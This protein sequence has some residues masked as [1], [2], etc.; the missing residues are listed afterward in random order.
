MYIKNVPT[1]SEQAGLENNFL[2]QVV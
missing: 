2:K 1:C